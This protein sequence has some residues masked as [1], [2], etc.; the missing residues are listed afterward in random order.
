M[1]DGLSKAILIVSF[2]GN[3]LS[4]GE[5][6]RTQLYTKSRIYT[7]NLVTT[8]SFLSTLTIIGA[9]KHKRYFPLHTH[10]G[11]TSQGSH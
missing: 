2:P 6:K 5:L 10:G 4:D 11:N 9:F 1:E 7:C 8:V 3:Q